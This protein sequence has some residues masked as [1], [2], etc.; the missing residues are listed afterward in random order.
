MH[1]YFSAGDKLPNAEFVQKAKESLQI[2]SD[3]VEA[4]F[5][6]QCTGAMN[7]LQQIERISGQFGPD[8]I[9]EITQI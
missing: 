6:F 1:K 2:A 8:E 5:G 4:K 3:R 9:I 7:S